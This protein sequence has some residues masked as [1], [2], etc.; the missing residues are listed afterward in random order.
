MNYGLAKNVKY[1]SLRH[2][3]GFGNIKMLLFLM[4]KCISND[5]RVV[6]TTATA[7]N[8]PDERWSKCVGHFKC[9]L[10]VKNRLFNKSCTVS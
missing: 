1:K 5:Q 10:L 6:I 7:D 9:I 4:A 8:D 3:T 2:I